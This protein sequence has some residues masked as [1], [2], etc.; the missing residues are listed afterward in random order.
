VPLDAF[1]GTFG[2]EEGFETVFAFG[3]ELEVRLGDAGPIPV[4]LVQAPGWVQ[5]TGF[6]L[7][8]NAL[9]RAM[10]VIVATAARAR[11]ESTP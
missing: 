1:C 7:P 2:F 3:L 6:V 8:V 9:A 11:G 10:I 4:L 5:T